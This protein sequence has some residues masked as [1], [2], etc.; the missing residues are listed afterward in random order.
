MSE[1]R[2][3]LAQTGRG[4][5]ADLSRFQRQAWSNLV[6]S[7]TRRCPLQ[8]AHCITSSVPD[9][10]LP[11]LDPDVASRWAGE[12][13][14]LARLGLRHVSF[15]GGEPTLALPQVE[16]IARAAHRAGIATSLVSS[17]SW[18][19]SP[20]QVERVMEALGNVIDSWDLGYDRF[21]AAFLPLENFA[22]A[23]NAAAKVSGSVC[24]RICDDR[25]AETRAIVARLWQQ[26]DPAVS[27]LV[28]PVHALGRGR[29]TP[30]SAARARPET[31]LCLATGPFVREDGTG[32]PC[33]AGLAYDARGRHPFDFGDAARDG[34]VAVWRRWREDQ[35]LRLFRLAG[36]TLPL[37]W[38]KEEGLSAEGAGDGHVC[39]TCVKLWDADGRAA[40]ILRE[41]AAD[42]ALAARLDD[43]ETTLFGGRWAE[44]A[45]QAPAY[46]HVA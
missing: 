14:D 17:G 23:A 41:R 12:M 8:C 45:E 11:L 19:R 24:V 10:A 16:A 18:G 2:S 5:A 46:D 4:S 9:R 32:G 20:R 43:L 1:A 33:C 40:T 35:L 3:F 13:E 34:L 22:Q 28:Q 31:M 38:L 21:H 26:L 6:F 36:L 37:A 25:G 29:D 39:E 42:P 30:A 7:V 15:T 44:T 27:L